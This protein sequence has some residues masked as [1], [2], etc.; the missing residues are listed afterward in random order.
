M[1][2]FGSE[3]EYEIRISP[4]MGIPLKDLD[5]EVSTYVYSNRAVTF[6]KTDTEHIKPVDNDTYMVVIDTE[7]A[8]KIGRGKEFAKITL[9]IPNN[10]FKD[11]IQT[12]ILKELETGWEF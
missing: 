8:L 6:K 2:S 7:N 4:I 9:H 12:V 5:F 3:H 11:G 10:H 1:L